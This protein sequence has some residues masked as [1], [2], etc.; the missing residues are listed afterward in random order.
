MW[1]RA[2]K[3][4]IIKYSKAINYQEVLE[5]LNKKYGIYS[6]ERKLLQM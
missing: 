3:S 2:T 5:R 4:D 1:S 6:K